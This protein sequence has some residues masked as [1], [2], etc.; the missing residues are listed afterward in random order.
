MK[1]ASTDLHFFTRLRRRAMQRATLA[2]RK[3]NEQRPVYK[4]SGV[5]D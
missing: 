3:C 2:G 5:I 4:D 1:A